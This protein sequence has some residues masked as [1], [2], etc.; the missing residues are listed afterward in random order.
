MENNLNLFFNFPIMKQITEF[1][2]EEEPVKS[3]EDIFKILEM[4]YLEPRL[5]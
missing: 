3:E 1:F 4:D 2:Q 5:R